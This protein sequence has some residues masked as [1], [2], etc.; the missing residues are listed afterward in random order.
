MD[1]RDFSVGRK[2]TL[3][4]ARNIEGMK[5]KFWQK[6]N[7]NTPQ[8]MW[9]KTDDLIPPFCRVAMRCKGEQGWA[10][11]HLTQY[12]VY[13]DI[14]DNFPHKLVIPNNSPSWTLRAILSKDNNDDVI[15]HFMH[16]YPYSN[17]STHTP[18]YR[19]MYAIYVHMHVY[20][21]ACVCVCVC[22]QYT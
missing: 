15:P 17:P 5:I 18:T 20:M 14:H 1:K 13:L 4:K 8:V 2:I 10:S 21:C 6:D 19:H 3:V 16:T 7:N 22:V 11:K 9:T 12:L